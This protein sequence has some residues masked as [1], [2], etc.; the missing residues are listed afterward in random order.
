MAYNPRDIIPVPRADVPTTGGATAIILTQLEV[1][2]AHAIGELK[3]RKNESKALVPVQAALP[4]AIIK[5][6][7]R[8]EYYMEW[9]QYGNHEADIDIG[10]FHTSNLKH[11]VKLFTSFKKFS[12]VYL[13]RC[14]D[15]KVLWDRRV[16]QQ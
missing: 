6:R 14:Q 1:I 9:W 3:F 5:R 15:D 2:E 16:R 7:T 13:R 8:R 4:P 11:F 10:H 12:L